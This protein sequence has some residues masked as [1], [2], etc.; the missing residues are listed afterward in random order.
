MAT[1]ATASSSNSH[2]RTSSTAE[3]SDANQ[4]VKRQAQ[5]AGADA[6][7]TP[8]SASRSSP[9]QEVYIVV[10]D[11]VPPYGDSFSDIHAVYATVKDANNAVKALAND[12]T[13]PEGCSYGS[14]DDGRVYWSSEDVGEGERVEISVRRMDTKRPGSE[15]ECEWGEFA[16]TTDDRDEERESEEEEI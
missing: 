10:V 15:P 11:S 14:K 2:K 1:T 8:N 5:D 12:Y 16:T 3:N 9:P 7:Q 6:K 4:Q 13:G